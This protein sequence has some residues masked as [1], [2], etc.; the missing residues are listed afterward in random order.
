MA[1]S[2]SAGAACKMSKMAELP[3]TMLG[4]RPLI[5]AKINNKDVRF[6]VDSGA[7]YSMISAA[8]AAELNLKIGA[9]PYG[10]RVIGIGGITKPSVATV[11]VFTLAGIPVRNM[12]FLVGGS[13][14]VLLRAGRRLREH[15]QTPT[16]DEGF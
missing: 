10:M 11:D 1:L 2:V 8:S 7:F 13:L 3:V 14:R 6:E 12:Q 15:R 5:D 16:G 9:A 4:L